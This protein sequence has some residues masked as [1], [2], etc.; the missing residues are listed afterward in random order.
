MTASMNPNDQ[1]QTEPTYKEVLDL[2]QIEMER[3]KAATPPM[4]INR[5]LTDAE[6]EWLE[7]GNVLMYLIQQM[8]EGICTPDITLKTFKTMKAL[9][10]MQ[11]LYPPTKPLQGKKPKTNTRK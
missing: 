5:P 3:L 8:H 10:T 11:A 6:I 4:P 2:F 9:K 1:G 7:E